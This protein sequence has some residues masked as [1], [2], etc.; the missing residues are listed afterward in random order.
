LVDYR[1]LAKRR[2]ALDAYLANLEAVKASEYTAWQVTQREAFW[3][4]AYNAYTVRLILDNYP[5]ES[6]R[7][8]G[9][10]F[11]PVWKKRHIPLQH[12]SPGH[13]RVLSLDEVE[14]GILA[15]ISRQPLFH[16]AIVC[17]STSCPELRAEAYVAA[18]LDGQLA[19]AGRRFLGDET[20][21]E[22]RKRDGRLHLSKIFD[23]SEDELVAFPGGIR[24]L[25]QKYG[26][27]E[28]RWASRASELP[29]AYLDYDWSL[30][31]WIP[32]RKKQ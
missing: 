25:L 22:A 13:R 17:A 16:F 6:I 30:N 26:P 11:S 20:K 4:N 14:H 28:M 12:L 2:G 1:G 19:A 21:N 9:G 31:E 8:L 15:D 10:F 29:I 5:V 18:E 27:E 32:P 3:I 7:D 24:G 23:W